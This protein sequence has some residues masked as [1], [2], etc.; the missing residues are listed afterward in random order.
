[1]QQDSIA[2]LYFAARSD[3]A[4]GV[5]HINGTFIINFS[6]SFFFSGG[7]GVLLVFVFI[8]FQF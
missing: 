3:R 8:F 6:F 1:L 4:L 2:R 7:G 5:L